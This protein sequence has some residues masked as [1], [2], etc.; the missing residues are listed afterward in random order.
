MVLNNRTNT[1][2]PYAHSGSLTREQFLFFEMR[3]T[4]KLMIDGLTDEEIYERIYSENLFQFPTEKSIKLI[5][6]GCI[7][8]LRAL[9]K[10]TGIEAKI[11]NRTGGMVDRNVFRFADIIGMKETPL[12]GK[13]EPYIWVEP[14]KTA[15]WYTPVNDAEKQRIADA[16]MAYVE[17]YQTPQQDPEMK[18]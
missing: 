17:L 11:I 1:N 7:R 6:S 9:D 2:S 18:M 8:R 12:C 15:S 5:T 10:Y 3:T 14:D 13:R 16:V 4:A